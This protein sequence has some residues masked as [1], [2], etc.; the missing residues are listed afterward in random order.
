M[1]EPD[2]RV[3]VVIPTYN[4]SE[5][6]A[7]TL[8]NLSRQTVPADRYEVVVADDGST[9][10]TVS[11]VR[12]FEGRLAVKYYFQEDLGFRAA[13]ARNGGARM[14]SAP[15][16]VFL[17][18]GSMVGP[19]FVARHLA[20]HGG[21]PSGRA[22]L[23]LSYGYN[24]EAPIEGVDE[25]LLTQT[26]EAVVARYGN[27]PD[28]QDIRH[29]DFVDCGFDLGRRAVPWMLFWTGNCSV[30]AADFWRVGGFDE[31]FRGWG[32]EDIELGH[33]IHNA[34]VSLELDPDIWAVV[35][36]HDRDASANDEALITN[37][38]RF[39][40]KAPEPIVEVGWGVVARYLIMPWESEY[41]R[42]LDWQEK[43]RGLTVAEEIATM[44][45]RIAPGERVA[46]FGCGGSVPG[47]LR[48]AVLADFDAEL[49]RTAVGGDVH[50]GHHAVGIRTVLPDRAVDA[51]IVTSRLAGLWDTWGDLIQ[52]EAARIGRRTLTFAD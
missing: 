3:S 13:A 30:A 49:L 16:L 22:V 48:P 20:A 10:D 2:R 19:E 38:T 33:R 51:V 23:G 26:P 52:R 44:A 47:A 29:P 41:Q 36:P 25:A 11:V 34:G 6:L 37:V 17:D 9:D 45:Q 40:T 31:D 8:H 4:Q 35:A 14:A 12:S 27:D 39:L 15:L 43:A 5:L 21:G 24:P 18:T 28:F 32:G 7:G 50:I 46:V 42:L 1:S